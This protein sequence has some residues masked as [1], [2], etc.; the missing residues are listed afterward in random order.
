M[1][2]NVEKE[3]GSTEPVKDTNQPPTPTEDAQP[4]KKKR[5]YKEFG[6]EEEKATRAY[7]SPAFYFQK[8]GL[9]HFYL[10]RCESGHVPSMPSPLNAQNVRILTFH[11]PDPTSRGG[12]VR[13]GQG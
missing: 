7:F 5:E 4:E 11:F 12:F 8:K 13:Q 2:T 10:D 9:T 6:H 3:A 1:S